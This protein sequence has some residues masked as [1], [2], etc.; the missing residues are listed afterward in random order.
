MFFF[1]RIFSIVSPHILEFSLSSR[2]RKVHANTPHLGPRGVGNHRVWKNVVEESR[3]EGGSEDGSSADSEED[4]LAQ[5]AG[6]IGGSRGG[7]ASGGAGA[8]GGRGV[9]AGLSHGGGS[10]DGEDGSGTHF[11]GV[12]GGFVVVV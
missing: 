1:F 4:V 6:A 8:V 3:L 12:W 11:D 2:S 7:L 5:G 10:E 9:A